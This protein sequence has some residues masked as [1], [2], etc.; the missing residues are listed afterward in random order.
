MALIIPGPLH[1]KSGSEADCEDLRSEARKWLLKC[2]VREQELEG[3]KLEIKGQK[4]EVVSKE[5]C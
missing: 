4:V 1:K 2:K 3:L 5:F